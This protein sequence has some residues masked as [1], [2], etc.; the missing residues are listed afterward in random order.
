M[1]LKGVN[2]VEQHIEKIVLVAVS[3]IFLLV[4]AAQLLY[5]PNKVKVGSGPAVPP[6]KAFLAADEKARA[7]KQSMEAA[8]IPDLPTAET[9]NLVAQFRT[10]FTAPVAQSATYAFGA[11]PNI[12]GNETKLGVKGTTAIN[13]VQ[14]PAPTRIAAA[15]FRSTIDPT[16][17]LNDPELKK[18]LPPEQPMDKAAVSVAAHFDGTALRAALAAAGKDDK[19]MPMPA[20][21]V[22]DGIEVL[23][24]RLERQEMLPKTNGSLSDGAWSDTIEV[25]AAPG[26]TNVLDQL[27]SVS[28]TADMEGVLSFARNSAEDIL[29]PAYYHSI[30]GPAWTLPGEG[31]AAIARNNPEVER[32]IREIGEVNKKLDDANKK[33]EE[34]DRMPVKDAK[35]GQSTGGGGGAGGKGGAG[36]QA[37]TP[38]QPTAITE[39][40][41]KSRLRQWDSTIQRL[42]NQKEA[43]E[44]FLKDQGLDPTGKPLAAEPTP[45]QN[46]PN[47]KAMG[48]R[49]MLDN[50]DIQV[51]AHDLTARPGKTYRYRVKVAINNPVFGRAASLVPE[52]Q[53]MAKSPYI[54]SAPSEWSEP[55]TVLDEKYFFITSA[56]EADNLGPAR[57]TVEMYQFFYG[58][59]R[60]GAANVEPGDPLAAAKLQLP[61]DLNKLPVYDL[62]KVGNIQPGQAAPGNPQPGR[63]G[64]AP[65]PTS[66]KGRAT[67]PQ[68]DRNE[69]GAAP[70]VNQPVPEQAKILLPDNAKPWSRPLNLTLD[71]Y[72]LDVVKGPGGG[73]AATQ[74]FLRDDA[75]HIVTRVPDEEKASEIFKRVAASAKEGENQGQPAALANPDKDKPKIPGPATPAGPKVVAPPPSGGG[76]GG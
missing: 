66:G 60:R 43:A 59:Y 54:Y 73:P 27:K 37:P 20:T 15:S 42:T 45:Q 38:N 8:E 13:P 35:T 17:P 71:V 2:P 9:T 36:G 14:A 12:K 7:L 3:A 4:V 46:Q 31:A 64:T 52:Q 68:P 47:E 58:Y 28:T 33:R 70:G 23:A 6:G 50:A 48:A 67:A 40:D 30:A 32:R 53:D 41:K 72:F 74:A 10:A 19:T 22:R 76:G 51:W 57:A 39:S 75:G 61:S 34:I 5:E 24:V 21:W 55:V 49:S 63:P 25:P 26:R 16:E 29:R 69:R 18:L 62:T 44:K 65:P 11:A 56:S 1:K